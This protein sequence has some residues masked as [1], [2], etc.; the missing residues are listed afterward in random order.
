MTKTTR[1]NRDGFG[2]TV[3]TSASDINLLLPTRR[4][5]TVA[6]TMELYQQA[7]GEEVREGRVRDHLF[8]L[9]RKDL[10]EK[11]AGGY[12]LVKGVPRRANTNAA[13]ARAK[14]LK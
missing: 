6:E 4:E 7:T 2:N 13:Q 14:E 9:M 3:G 11:T 1:S 10:V 12:K 5:F 8:T